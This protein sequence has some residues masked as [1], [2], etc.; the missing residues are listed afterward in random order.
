[1]RWRL[2]LGGVPM[3]VAMLL[4]ASVASGA[5]TPPACSPVR[6]TAPSLR[7]LAK[8]ARR[9]LG[10]AD[11]IASV[12]IA[13]PPKYFWGK[14]FSPRNYP[15]TRLSPWIY[16][17]VEP[18]DETSAAGRVARQRAIWQS[19]MF[20]QSLHAAVCTAGTEPEAGDSGQTPHSAGA[21]DL[22]SGAVT[23][24]ALLRDWPYARVGQA[25]RSRLRALS[26]RY[27]FRVKSL[28]VL[29]ADGDAPQIRVESDH[30]KQFNTQLSVIVR[31]L[32]ASPTPNCWAS[33][34]C[35]NGLWIE[36]DDAAGSPFLATASVLAGPAQNGGYGAQWVRTGL[37]YPYPHG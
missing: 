22:G 7:A 11:Q 14:T 17:R 13:S 29:H 21:F 2:S 8:V 12:R 25:F 15:I 24:L 18:V 37:P 36:A 23:N 33:D 9:R 4:C 32:E 27:G 20:V 34:T 3:V 1:M 26:R 16:V 35:V 28:V 5:T 6:A 31:K 10:A 30:P 19:A